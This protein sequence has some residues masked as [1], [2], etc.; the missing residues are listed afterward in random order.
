M[1]LTGMIQNWWSELMAYKRKSKAFKCPAC[2]KDFDTK[3]QLLSHLA[4]KHP[5]RIK[6]KEGD[7]HD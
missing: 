6:Y 3:R 5:E 2:E 4:D 7:S 1:V